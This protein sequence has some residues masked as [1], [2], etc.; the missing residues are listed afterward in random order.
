MIGGKFFFPGPFMH[1]HKL[2]N[3]STS[4]FNAN[5]TAMEHVLKNLSYHSQII[6]Q[7]PINSCKICM[8]DP[9]DHNEKLEAPCCSNFQKGNDHMARDETILTAT[10][11][12]CMA[13]TLLSN[14]QNLQKVENYIVIFNGS[15]LGHAWHTWCRKG[16]SGNK[17]SCSL[18][19]CHTK[20]FKLIDIRTMGLSIWITFF[21][22]TVYRGGWG[23]LSHFSDFG[24]W[25]LN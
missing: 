4:D 17:T 14:G 10:L 7:T 24:L 20:I 3:K 15:V 5:F 1:P 13:M 23:K 2:F 9:Q 11:L 18:L 22:R 16:T 19:V 6:A 12:H 8:K 21:I 25:E